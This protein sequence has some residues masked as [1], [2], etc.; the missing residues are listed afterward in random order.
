M[1]RIEQ[2]SGSDTRFFSLPSELFREGALIG[3]DTMDGVIPGGQFYDGVITFNIHVPVEPV[4]KAIE[5]AVSAGLFAAFLSL[6]V[7]C[8]CVDPARHLWYTLFADNGYEGLK[9]K[10]LATA[11]EKRRK[12]IG[13]RCAVFIGVA[14]VCIGLRAVVVLVIPLKKNSPLLAGCFLFFNL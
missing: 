1:I 5:Y 12:A 3:F 4:L 9:P 6:F 14:Y 10:E 11:K 13:L 7:C 8:W 2:V